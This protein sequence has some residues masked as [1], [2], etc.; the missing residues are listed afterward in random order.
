MAATRLVV[1][2]AVVGYGILAVFCR[3]HRSNGNVIVP[4][5]DT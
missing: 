4:L 1:V 3:P 2:Y 5:N